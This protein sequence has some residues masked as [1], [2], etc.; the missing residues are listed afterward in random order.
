MEEKTTQTFMDHPF[1][2][3]TSYADKLKYL[4]EVVQQ[5]DTVGIII[6][7]DPDA[8]ASALAL[9][10]L[11]W[12][13]VKHVYIYH[14][15]RIKRSDNL[16]FTTLLKV[17]QQHIRHLKRSGITKWAIVDGQPEH[18]DKFIGF[19]FD[20]MIDH[21]PALPASTAH[22]VDIREEY[23]ATS[24]IMTEYLRAA[25]IKPSP[26][27]ATALFYGIKTD[28]DNF[29][30]ECIPND[31]NAFRY[32][33]NFANMNII[34][35]IESSEMTRKTLS[36]FRLAIDK[37][38]FFDDVA[39]VHMNKVDN[40]D[41]MVIIADFLL[42]LAEARWSIVSG[43]YDKNLVLIFRNATFRGNAGNMAKK[44]FGHWGGHAGG[45]AAAAR[46][47]IP[48]SMIR[49]E[50]KGRADLAGFVRR[51]LKERMKE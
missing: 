10:R 31:L 37:L 35:K 3:S 9:K 30:R 33:Y 18:G 4:D 49:T 20:I 14:V 51:N 38:N 46:A 12:R 11:L 32:L 47:E 15:N 36:Q 5:R 34:R 7:A 23:G 29:V 43:V 26:R 50:V 44:L 24:T 22:F 25:K 45:H 28:T 41:I 6:D 27:L 2:K 42:K 13:K 40:P 39:Y 1:P 19:P 21:H 16:A 17:Q 8:M 48:L